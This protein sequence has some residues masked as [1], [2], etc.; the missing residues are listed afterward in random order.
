MITLINLLIFLLLSRARLFQNSIVLGQQT[1]VRIL[2]VKVFLP[3]S[4][5]FLFNIPRVRPA[6]ELAKQ[7]IEAENRL[8]T[9]NLVFSY[10]DSQCSSTLGPLHAVTAF[11]EN[12]GHLF[13]GPVCDFSL[14][15]IARWLKYWDLPLLSVGGLSSGFGQNKSHSKSENYLLT[16]MG[17]T[18]N[19]VND[20]FF[21][22]TK[23]FG[24]QKVFLVFQ[25][26]GR[27]KL[28]SDTFCKIFIQGVTEK[29]IKYSSHQ[30]PENPTREQIRKML[31]N[32]IGFEFGVILMCL[33][34]D[35]I[36]EVL[37]AAD[38]LN[39]V[40]SGEYV[41]FSMELY[42]SKNEILWPWYRES[43]T[44][45]ENERA[46]KAYEALLTI[47]SPIPETP[48][49][50]KF[51]ED[52]KQLAK[53][54]V[55]F[56][57]QTEEVNM[58]VSGFYEAM[59]LYALALNETLS[60]GFDVVNGSVITSKM[61]NRT[62]LGI[63]GNV[64]IDSN[65][66]RY[67]NYALMDL[68][69]ETGTFEVV[70]NYFQESKQ[71]VE[72]EGK[73]IHWSGGRQVPPLDTPVCGYDRSKCPE[74]EIPQYVIIIAVMS[75]LM[76][77]LVIIS[78][79]IYR[80]FKLEADIASM[81]WKIKYEEILTS[82]SYRRPLGSR[83]STVRSSIPSSHSTETLQ[84]GEQFRQVFT[85]TGFYK[86]TMV[87]IKPINKFRVEV[88]RQLLLEL[89]RMKDLQH[90]HLVRFIGACVDPTFCCL[91]T[92]YCPRG[93]LQ[94]VLENDQIQLDWMF[95]YSLMHDL[96]KGM[97]F[98]H[99]TEFRS[100]GNLK[101]SNCV[102]DSRFILKITDF[103][104]HSL[105][106][107]DENENENSYAYWRKS[108]WTAPELL[109]KGNSQPGGTQK[110]DVYGFAIIVHEIVVRQG[111]FYLGTLDLSPKEIVENVK[112]GHNPPFRPVIQDISY[113]EELV[114]MMKRCWAEDPSERPD[115]QS[116][117][118]VIRKLNRTNE[119][120]NILDNLLSRMEQYANNL[121][122]LVE[123]RTADY[124][125]EK[126]KAENLLYQL[127]PKSVAS[128]LILGESVTAEAFDSVTIY[129]SDI[130]GFTALSAE[131]TPLQVVDFLNDLYTCFDS[132][133]ENFHVYK[134]ETIGDAYMVVSGLPERNG[135]IH[136]REIAR[137]S[138]ALLNAVMSFS[139][140][141]RPQEQLKLRI[142]IH[143]GSCV[144]GVVGLKMP[145]YCL[146]GDTVNTASRME[147]TGL[148]L[149]IHVSPTTK[150]VLD[151][152]GTFSLELR[153]QVEMKGKGRLTTY[154]LL[155]EKHS[156][157]QESFSAD[158]VVKHTKL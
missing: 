49:Y 148:P 57:Y 109:R 125:E 58:F 76:V 84:V 75:G 104:L 103:G 135:N 85:V 118:G 146:F 48:E 105:R 39:M 156:S 95:R 158:G 14:A 139:I 133:I 152:F 24:W 129:F 131:S 64:T 119:S 155:E 140:R 141:H 72:V 108:L 34:P 138:L 69:P 151:T 26:T 44:A 89:K 10:K 47:T 154:W 56:D 73:K 80:H 83:M 38:E 143:S 128:Q 147:S 66:D 29:I 90:D 100:H 136:A 50:K 31:T 1:S 4:S 149:K 124:L 2:K 142:G 7:R 63:S 19:G 59:I 43:D 60:E 150:E 153:G 18:F 157:L 117:K 112:S 70:A 61:W 23:K 15:P 68:N 30:M 98:L 9:W 115:F 86:G 106:T 71:L 96:I 3:Q 5:T 27:P 35:T 40:D 122:S 53:N 36:R 79:F 101:S 54:D 94:D 46:R 32:S 52:V 78:F 93:S 92:E 121:E 114:Q 102:V 127:L 123:E 17:Q 20:L 45:E 8:P 99:S 12:D 116:L 137:M 113:D 33:S 82:S 25:I 11:A 144:A 110:G 16:R 77:V 22:V 67:V 28:S 42:A 130:V 41:F 74:N 111:P 134:V 81:T 145:R 120:G 91:V 87:A 6:I 55:H 107:Y 65:G 13:L 21:F 97:A 37:L 51:A 126:E 62:F 88:H 132:I